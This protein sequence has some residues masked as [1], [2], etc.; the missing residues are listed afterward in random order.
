MWAS[1][2]P[3][4]ALPPPPIRTSLT[5][6]PLLVADPLAALTASACRPLVKGSCFHRSAR[7]PTNAEDE[8]AAAYPAGEW[9]SLETALC[10]PRP[11]PCTRIRPPSP[12]AVAN[13]AQSPA[14]C[15]WQKGGALGR[16][17]CRPLS[18]GQRAACRPRNTRELSAGI[19][20]KLALHNLHPPTHAHCCGHPAAACNSIC[21]DSPRRLPHLL[22][23][24]FKPHI[25]PDR[26]CSGTT[27]AAPDSA[28]VRHTPAAAPCC[29]CIAA[30]LPLCTCPARRI[31][32][33]A[34]RCGRGVT[35]L[36]PTERR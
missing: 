9:R 15:T 13:A 17:G 1:S 18:L 6:W 4:D 2:P 10:M 14:I 35:T 26:S 36:S 11:S 16:K 29:C 28:Q 7:E 34:A 32:C 24:R 33:C 31:P 27:L 23:Y 12:S 8:A 19:S 5:A 3:C 22:C 21:P 30:A 25:P 20:S